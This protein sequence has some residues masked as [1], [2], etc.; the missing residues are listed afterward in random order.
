MRLAFIFSLLITGCLFTGHFVLAKEQAAA[1]AAAPAAERFNGAVAQAENPSFRRHIVPL[2]SR[3]GCSGRECHGSFQGRGGFHLSLFGYDFEKD[4]K[5]MTVNADGGENQ[6]RINREQPEKSLLLTKPTL[7]EPHKG[8]ERFKKGSWEYNLVLKWIQGGAKMDVEATGEFGHL[9][10]TPKEI[11]FKKPGD[12]VQIRVLAHW[13]D[14][15]VE[16]VTQLTRFRSNDDSVSTVSVTGLVESKDKGDTHVVAFYDNGVHPVPVMLPVSDKVGPKYPQVASVSKVDDLVVGKLRKLGI[17]PSETCTDAEFLRRVSLDVTGTLPTPEEITAFLADRSPSKRAAKVDALLKTPAYAAWWATKLSD[18][19]GNNP[20]VLRGNGQNNYGERF[21]RQWYDWMQERFAKNEPY[22]QMMAGIILA[23]GRTK[24][25]Q[26]Y[27]E[28]A[29]EMSGY[30]RAENPLKFAERPNMPYFWQRSNLQKAE[31]KALA[32]SHSFLGVRIECAQCHKHPFDQW[33]QNDF[34]AFQAFF[35]GVSYGGKGGGGKAGGGLPAQTGETVTYASLT[36]AIKD[37][38]A[39]PADP[40]GGNNQKTLSEE[41]ERRVK[42]GEPAPWLEVFTTV[43]ETKGELSERE[44]ERM[45]KRN[46]NFDGRVL[47]PKILGGEE[48]MLKEFPDPRAPLMEWLR[49]AKNPYFAKAWVNRVWASYFHRGLV[50]PADDMNLA[51]PPV[52]EELMDYLAAGFVK[53]GY[54]MAWLHKEILT[55]ATYQRSWKPN[56]TN[57]N[58]EKNFSR[59]VIRRL[60]AELVVDGIMQATLSTERIGK[61]RDEIETRAIGPNANAGRAGGG[62]GGKGVSNYSLNIF[63][64]PVR[65]TNCDCERTTDPTLLQTLFTRNDPELLNALEQS[66]GS[67]W[68]DE[69]RKATTPAS[70]ARAKGDIAQLEDLIRKME[71]KLKESPDRRELLEG[72]IKAAKEK[73]AKLQPGAAATK[74]TE[75]GLDGYITQVFLRTVSRPPTATEIEKARADLSA[76]NSTA[77]GVRELL[78]AM[79]NTR[80][81][82]VNH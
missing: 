64:K 7:Q 80:E 12:T 23:T 82:M 27:E 2:F 78:W 44:I 47:T 79:L 46:P 9:E 48:V 75:A 11:V 56:D 52:N 71:T 67:G 6:V 40:K 38:V 70:P 60:P 42:A 53:S 50:E 62:G 25:G 63:G 26:T 57:K 76:A 54:N 29:R 35:E 1:P 81:F 21:S 43:R 58:D 34:K 30:F 15:T 41:F 72:E 22:D 74:P 61:F 20:R 16:D 36:K 39:V 3:A 31:E 45:K 37:A 8:K 65:E 4:H 73:L 68:V 51:N 13:K 66:R 69:I 28:F 24:A 33:T 77:E 19:L 55:S 5:Q 17:I 49:S 10:I 18:F 14:G 59:A 32:F